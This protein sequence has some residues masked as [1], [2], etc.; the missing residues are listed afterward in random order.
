MNR[1]HAV[2]GGFAA[3]VMVLTGCAGST[4]L[5][6]V[7][8]DPGVA[9]QRLH[10]VMVT[11]VA[12]TPAV[13]RDFED[14]FAA[15][16]RRRGI[17][18]EPSYRLVSEAELDSAR[19]SL[20]MH[21]GHCDGVLV[22]RIL[23]EETVRTYYPPSPQYRYR[24]LSHYYGGW[25]SYYRYGYAYAATPGYTVENKLVRMETNLYRV[26][27][28]ALVWSAVSKTWLQASGAPGEA[29]DAVVSQLVRGLAKSA[30]VAGTRR[31]SEERR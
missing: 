15:A 25:Y 8:S 19:T 24:P 16:L 22:T 11:N 3:A 13:R 14:R 27:D 10:K 1:T 21:E 9:P 6:N 2:L 28:N 29:T 12:K 18:A 23:D 26:S 30:A 20:A 31:T 17:Q 5:T 7:W 4:R